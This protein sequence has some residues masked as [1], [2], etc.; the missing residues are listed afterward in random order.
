MLPFLRI[1]TEKW[2]MTKDVANDHQSPNISLLQILCYFV[3]QCFDAVS[4]VI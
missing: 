1:C 2:Q 4:W 3:L